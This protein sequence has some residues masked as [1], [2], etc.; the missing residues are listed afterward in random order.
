LHQ[1]RTTARP[2]PGYAGVILNQT[3][4]FRSVCRVYAPLYRQ[5][6]LTALRSRV[7]G[8]TMPIDGKA[9]YDDVPPPANSRFG[10]VRGA[11]SDRSQQSA[12]TNPAQL[13]G[14]EGRLQAYLAAGDSGFSVETERTNWLKDKAAPTTP[15]VSVPGLLTAK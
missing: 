9:A 5:V 8:E 12:C 4:R 10:R 3:A 7:L 1:H 2:K 11:E 15:F 13:D 6:N 14:S